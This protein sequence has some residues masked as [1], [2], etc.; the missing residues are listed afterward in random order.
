[1]VLGNLASVDSTEPCDLEAG[2]VVELKSRLAVW[3][4]E[5]GGA[6]SS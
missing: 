4:E 3:D 6:C 1:M 5:Q 2:E